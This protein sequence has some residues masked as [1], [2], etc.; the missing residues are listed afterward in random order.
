MTSS[1]GSRPRCP[2]PP[3]PPPHSVLLQWP[4]F[5]L[6]CSRAP[7]AAPAAVTVTAYKI[8]VDLPALSGGPSR[9]A[10]DPAGGSE[11]RRRLLLHVRLYERDRG[12]QDGDHQL[13]ARAARQPRVGSQMLRGGSSG[14]RPPVRPAAR[15]ARRGST[16]FI[17]GGIAGCHAPVPGTVYNAEPL[18][19]EPGRLGVV[20]P[21]PP[22]DAHLVDP[23]RDHPA[24]RERLWPDRDAD[25]HQPAAVAAVPTDLQVGLGFMLNGSTNKYVR[26][27][28]S[29]VT[30]TRPARR[31]ATTTRPS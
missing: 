17:A 16:P 14:R 30:S 21:T 13:R 23:V 11:S 20:T 25:R 7:A 4:A 29:C 22:R 3:P 2:P 9:R 1:N 12:H 8:I 6:L 24:R 10:L 18:G 28:T 27:P 26:N 5:L 19:N 31:S 15:S